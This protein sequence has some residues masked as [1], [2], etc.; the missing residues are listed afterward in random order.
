MLN[1][2]ELANS[3]TP[4]PKG[5]GEDPY[6]NS[7]DITRKNPIGRAQDKFF[8]ALSSDDRIPATRELKNVTLRSVS[9]TTVSIVFFLHFSESEQLACFDHLSADDE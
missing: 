1:Y 2:N 5:G 6:H 9:R 8:T 7:G 4:D 3:I